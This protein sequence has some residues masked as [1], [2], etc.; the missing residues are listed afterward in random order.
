V[1]LSAIA[2]DAR[3]RD[4]ALVWRCRSG[5]EAAWTALVERFADYV[6]AILVRGFELDDAAAE[7]AFQEVFTRVFRRLDSLQDDSAIKPWIA[8]VSRRVAVDKLRATHAEADIEAL[9]DAGGPD[10]AFELIDRAETVRRALAELPEAYRDV[11][12]RFF[13]RDQSYQTIAAEVDLP[14][15]TIASRISRGLSML[16]AMCA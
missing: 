12:E 5:D 10:P 7:D 11:V 14:A 15:G 16:R 9:L 1:G 3:R 8:Q 4:A 13:I 6:Y 2:E